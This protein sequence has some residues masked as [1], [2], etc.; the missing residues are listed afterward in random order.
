MK[1][2]AKIR[3]S[4]YQ[5]QDVA[6]DIYIYGYPL[7]VSEMTRRRST[8]VLQPSFRRAPVNQFA[9]RRF[10]AAPYEKDDIHPHA[11]C[12]RSSAWLDLRKEPLVLCLPRIER[13]YLFALWSGW[14][15]IFDTL[16]TWHTD[17]P[18]GD[19][20]L[21]APRFSQTLPEVS[22]QITA[23]TDT[24]WLD[25]YFEIGAVDDIGTVHSIQDQL[26]LAPLS[27]WQSGR[28]PH[29]IPVLA[30]GP[31]FVTPQ[32]QVEHMDAH[33]FY[34]LLSRL[35]DRNPPKAN[36]AAMVT[37]FANIGF[38]ASRDFAFEKLPY[39]VSQAM[40]SAILGAHARIVEAA[41]TCPHPGPNKWWRHVHPGSFDTN[42]L[43]RAAARIVQASLLRFNGFRH[44]LFSR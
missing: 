8:A 28:G 26:R 7:V 17:S 27:E 21:C 18:G 41:G 39:P 25:G 19:F 11:D 31:T 22:R 9:H 30:D 6:E 43:A 10:P 4:Q 12:L 2:P 32:K 37:D 16:G 44:P 29:S 36:E 24:V 3:A 1:S 20:V 38:T 14:Y 40:S 33:V 34:N 35:L 15:E 5:I 42:Y 23:P 13:Y